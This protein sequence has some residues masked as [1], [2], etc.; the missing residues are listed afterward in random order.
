M[1]TFAATF[2]EPPREVI[3]ALQRLIDGYVQQGGGQGA[4]AADR[5]LRARPSAAIMSLPRGEGGLAAADIGLQAIALRAKVALRLLHPEPRVWK[6]LAGAAFDAAYPGL[7]CSVMLTGIRYDVRSAS[8]PLPDHLASGWRALSALRPFRLV[9]LEQMLRPTVQAEPLAGSMRVGLGRGA[10]VALGWRAALREWP[11][12]RRVRDLCPNSV[13]QLAAVLPPAWRTALAGPPP[14]CEWEVTADSAWVRFNRPRH[15]RLFS[16][17]PDGRLREESLSRVPGASAG[18]RAACVVASPLA[19]G[20]PA[21]VVQPPPPVRPW[22]WLES[23]YAAMLVHAA[24]AAGVPS[25]QHEDLFL[26]GPWASA[27]HDIMQWGIASDTH[28]LTYTARAGTLRLARLR[29]HEQHT[30]VYA[31]AAA[32]APALSGPGR[33][34][35]L[36]AR[37]E[38]VFRRKFAGSR[39]SAPSRLPVDDD[40]LASLYREPWMDPSPPR[41][42]PLERAARARDPSGLGVAPD[43]PAA[44]QG[45]LG[46]GG[47]DVGPSSS[48]GGQAAGGVGD[49]DAAGGGSQAGGVGRDGRREDT[50]DALQPRPAPEARAVWRRVFDKRR[51]RAERS[52]W[53]LLRHAALDCGGGRTAFCPAER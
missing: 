6:A 51:T 12:A 45:A 53:F 26:V 37:Q 3:P 41:L 39:H 24:S 42:H 49:A 28:L 33:A 34:A 14:A 31:P 43:G 16:V 35:A 50:T 10:Q 25:E 4:A 17:G 13:G 52:F 1:A 32:V 30:Q 21:V 46:R 8:S 40:T 11:Q 15:Q 27:P 22:P 38:E 23:R 9:P 18:W 7:G 5:P 36:A 47:S 19:K 29:A 20:R 48:G 44:T 2:V